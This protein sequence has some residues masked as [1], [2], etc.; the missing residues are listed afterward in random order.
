V[1]DGFSGDETAGLASLVGATGATGATGAAGATGAT[2][3]QGPQGDPGATGATGATGAAG[4]TGATGAAGASAYTYVA[5]ASASDGTGFSL[6]PGSGLN[7]IAFKTTTSPIGS[8]A[9]GDFTGL[10]KE[11]V[12]GGGSALTIE[13]E[14]TPLSTAATTLDF[15]GAGVTVTG[16][17]AEKTITIPGG[18]GGGGRVLIDSQT[19]SS[20]A[21]LTFDSVFDSTYDKYLIEVRNFLPATDSVLCLLNLRDAAADLLTGTSHFAAID[22]KSGVVGSGLIGYTQT[23]AWSLSYNGANFIG[24][25]ANEGCLWD[26][27]LDPSMAAT[28]RSIQYQ[29][30]YV[31]TGG[32]IIGVSDAF[33]SVARTSSHDG[34]KIAFSSGN[35]AS[36]TVKVWGIPKT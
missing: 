29:G 2:G 24:N 20:S 35:I 15:V 6:S 31:N 22:Y 30:H 36:G 33:G 9:A 16:S 19:A 10:W 7:F 23:G 28:S 26:I 25:A 12:G 17:G 8:P 4:A 1:A 3:P 11:Y 21:A 18:G 32:D 5:Y 27:Y 13:D 14:G 34:F